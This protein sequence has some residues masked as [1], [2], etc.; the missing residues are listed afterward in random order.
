MSRTFAVGLALVACAGGARAQTGRGAARRSHALLAQAQSL[1]RGIAVR[2]SVANARTAWERRAR[3]FDA[4][5]LTVLLPDAVGTETGFRI[6]A[7]AAEYLRDA[8]P[9]RF[10]AV[11]VVVALAATGVDSTVRTERL[12]NRARIPVGVE[13]RPDTLADGWSVAA[14]VAWDYRETLDSTWRGWLPPDL[15]LGWTPKR[16]GPATV[17]ELM[18]GDT[19]VGAGCLE[20]KV[21]ACRLWLGLDADTEPYKVRY[22]PRELQALVSGR[23]FPTHQ[24]AELA[25]QCAAEARDA[26]L[27]LT[28][29]GYLPP[30]PAGPSPR[31]SFV[32]FVLTRSRPGALPQALQDRA[33]SVGDRLVRATGV[34][35]DSLVQGWRAWV[36]T[37]GGMPEVTANL[38]DAWPVAV[39]AGLLVLAAA[40]SGRWR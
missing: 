16:D 34:A 30:I 13:P 29:L 23:W 31:A 38:R 26:C 37:E 22:R 21:D 19:R 5:P 15:G 20:G 35:E 27:R 24:S 33:G 9:A 12:R 7:G 8:L 40:R 36:L 10:L 18:R 3:R 17:R 6:T 39:F 11:R 25:Q 28:S 1:W 4:G 2:D 14:A 32:R